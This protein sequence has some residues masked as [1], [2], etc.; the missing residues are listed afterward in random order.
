MEEA[1]DFT[2]C[3][4]VGDDVACGAVLKAVVVVVVVV[5]VVIVGGA[6]AA[7]AAAVPIAFGALPVCVAS[8]RVG[9]SMMSRHPLPAPRAR[10]W[11]VGRD[12]YFLQE[13][14]S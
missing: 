10:D 8:G 1:V 7:A 9:M 2:A 12:S 14:R 4:V 3:V 6:A 5:V 11:E 13:C